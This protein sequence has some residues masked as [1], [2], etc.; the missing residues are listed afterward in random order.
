MKKLSPYYCPNCR[1]I[2]LYITFEDLLGQE[3]TYYLC[4]KCGYERIGE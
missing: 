4:P 2:R 1:F 3:G